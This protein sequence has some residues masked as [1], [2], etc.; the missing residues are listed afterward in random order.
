MQN[1]AD[2]TRRE[3]ADSPVAWFVVLERA[4]LDQDFRRAHGAMRE[5]QRLGVTVKY[6]K[7]KGPRHD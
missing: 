6:R 2:K 3:A 7:P 1:Q 5:L 4:R